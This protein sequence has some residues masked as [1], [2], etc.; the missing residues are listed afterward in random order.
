MLSTALIS[1][2]HCSS[3]ANIETF[4]C[5]NI[6]SNYVFSLIFDLPD[7]G[8]PCGIQRIRQNCNVV[9]L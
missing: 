8:D 9:K 1:L 3:E 6:Y 5:I 7:T 2:L 4:T